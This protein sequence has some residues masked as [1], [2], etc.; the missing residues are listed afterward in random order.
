MIGYLDK[1]LGAL[2]FI[3]FKMS[4]YVKTFKIKDGEQDK[5]NKL[6]SFHIDDNKLLEKYKTTWTKIGDQSMM[7]DI[8]YIKTKIGTHGD[9]V[10]TNFRGLNVPENGVECESCT[11]ISI[12]SLLVYENKYYQQVYLDK[13]AY[14]I[15]YKQMIDYL[16]ETDEG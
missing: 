5:N 12:D 7:I 3:L 15:V 4:G 10:C 9:K 13:C 14:K 11:V 2:V 6:T 16:F 8:R 1:V